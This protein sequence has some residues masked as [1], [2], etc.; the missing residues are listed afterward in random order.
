MTFQVVTSATP[1]YLPGVVALRNSLK[2]HFPEAKLA[3]FYYTKDIDIALPQDV[4]Y[5]IDAEMPGP[6]LDEGVPFRHGLPLGPDMF[7]R[8]LIPKYFTG[9]AFYVDADCIVLDTLKEL[10]ELDLEDYPT[11]CVFRPDVGWIGGN[12]HD[13]MASG[14]YLCDCDKWEDLQLTEQIFQ[15]MKDKREG[16]ITRKFHVNVE[17]VMSYAHDGQF[18][19]LPAE[20][21]NLT[22][23]GELIKTDKV[24]HFAG[25]KPWKIQRVRSARFNSR[26]NYGELW[27]AYYSH[28]LRHIERERSKLPKERSRNPWD[29]RKR[30]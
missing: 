28:D 10:W 30:R 7:A 20:Y 18:Y 19:H 27:K 2:I 14:T 6:V 17:S 5:I 29:R 1:E 21:Q 22:Y 4:D 12:R 23:Y 25:P 9:K 11:A 8:L 3:C 15:V 24:A 16:K 26:L 13:D